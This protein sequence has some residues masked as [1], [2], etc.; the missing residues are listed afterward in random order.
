[1]S[2]VKSIALLAFVLL[3]EVATCL[4]DSG[5]VEVVATTRYNVG[6][7]FH[8]FDATFKAHPESARSN[9]LGDF[10]KSIEF[11]YAR[12]IKSNQ[13]IGAAENILKITLPESTLASI[14]ERIN[15]LNAAYDNVERGDTYT[16]QYHPKSGTTLLRNGKVVETI[17][18]ADFQRAYFSIW[19]GPDSP[20]GLSPKD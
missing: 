12:K 6:G 8:V 4:E 13:L 18:G 5:D 10:P 15:K 2:A 3:A 7:V 16:L 11:T 17:A 19:L 14:G 1:M 20:F 9:P